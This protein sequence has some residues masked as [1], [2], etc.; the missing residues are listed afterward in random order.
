MA[1]SELQDDGL[2]A[3]DADHL[4]EPS[5]TKIGIRKSTFLRS[6]MYEFIEE[7]AP[8]LTKER[9]EQAMEAATQEEVDAIFTNVELPTY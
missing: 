2:V 4:F 9:V 3:L 1:V 8:H 6:F 7:F 5:T